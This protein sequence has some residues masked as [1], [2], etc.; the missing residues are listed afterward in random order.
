MKLYACPGTCSLAPH[1]MLRETGQPFQLVPVDISTHRTADGRD[2]YAINRRGQVPALELDDGEL[3]TEGPIIAQYIADR[4]GAIEL[5]PAAGTL[6]RYRVMEWQNYITTELH[7]SFTPLFSGD[8]DAAAKAV[9]AR[10]LRQKFEWVDAQL[11]GRR[12][13]TGDAFTAADIYLYVVSGWARLVKL[14]ISDLANLQSFLGRV[15]E[16]PAV[17]AAHQAEMQKAA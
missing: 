12:F 6:Q 1:I 4:A 9:H 7:K 15:A 8:F 10:K 5:M 17:R 2:Y 14:D 11:A 13:L 3:L 16:R